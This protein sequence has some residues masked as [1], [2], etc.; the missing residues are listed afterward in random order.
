MAGEYRI[1]SL[2]ATGI[3]EILDAF[4]KAFCDYAVNF[5][6]T[7]IGAMLE[8]RGFNPALSYAALIDGQIAAFTLNG[9]GVYDGTA[10]C[11]DCGTGTCPEYRGMGL[12][13]MIFRHSVPLLKQAGI[14]QYLLEVLQ[15]NAPAISIYKSNGFCISAR[16][17]CYNQNV[18]ELQLNR[19][20]SIEIDIQQTDC[21]TIRNLQGFCDF[22]PSWQNDIESIERAAAGL[23]ITAAYHSRQAVGYCV[24]D[25]Q[26]GDI[27]QIAVSESFRRKG[28]ATRLLAD[29]VGKF[30]AKTIKVLNV[31]SEN[32]SLPAFLHAVNIAD[33]LSQYAMINKL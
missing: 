5:D 29:A 33:G 1:I 22:K 21:N 16:Y 7:Q 11:Y 8:R 31:D 26:S 13:G 25:P 30:E 17:N 23:N 27:A 2:A 10:T 20:K 12:A 3:D 14:H 32:R 28:I 4:Q 24:S 18:S 6:R 15:D 9:T 19:A